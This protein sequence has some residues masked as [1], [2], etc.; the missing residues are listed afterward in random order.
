MV[1]ALVTIALAVRLTSKEEIGAYFLIMVVAQFGAIL[2][3]VGLKN[4]A[5]KTLSVSLPADAAHTA[6]FL[7]TA[8][9]ISSLATALVVTIALPLVT[10]LWP[11]PE[12]R[13]HAWLEVAPVVWTECSLP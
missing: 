3:D 1:A 13:E 6:R 5:I 8:T 10:Q 4:T 9:L 7:V 2:G 11:Y 12:F